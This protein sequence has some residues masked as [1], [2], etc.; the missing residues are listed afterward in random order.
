MPNLLYSLHDRDAHPLVP[1]GGWCIESIALNEN[2]QPQNWTQVRGDINWILRLNY[3]HNGKDGTIPL[4]GQYDEFA[5]RCTDYM[6]GTKGCNIVVIANEPNHEQE[7]PGGVPISPEDYADCFNLCFRAITNERPDVEVLTAAIAP[8]DITSGMDWLAYY[9]RMLAGVIECDGLAVHGYSHGADPDLIWSTEKKDGWYWHFPVI[10]QTIQAIPPEF[11]TRPI[12][13]TETDQGDNAWV[14]ANTGWV[15]NAYQSVNDHN[16]TPGTQ[17]ICSLALYRWRGDKYQIYNKNGVQDDFRAAV[18]HGYRSPLADIGPLPTPPTPEPP[19]PTPEPPRPT[20]EPEPDLDPRSID[21][22]LYARGVTFA[23]VKAPAGSGYW[24]IKA[25]RWLDE[26]EADAVG[27]DHHIL[28]SI[29]IDGSEVPDVP[30]KVTWPSGSANVVSKRDQPTATYNY[31]FPMS[32]SLN[33]FAIM[34]DDGPPSDL[35]MGIGMGKLGNPSIHTSTLIDWEWTISEGVIEPSPPT[36]PPPVLPQ[37]ERLI[38][39]VVGPVT[40]RWGENPD[41]YQQALGIPYHNG[42]DIGVPI[43]TEVRASGDGIIKWVDD[44]PQGY[45][46]YC[47]LYVPAV[48]QH[49]VTAHLDRCLVQ[50]GTEVKQGQVI[51]YSGNSGLSSGPHVH[52]ETRAGTEHS[53]AQG[54]FGNSNGRAD[55]QAVFWALGGTQEPIAGPGR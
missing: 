21:P 54:T 34:V 55:P 37:A 35:A 46:L 30:L 49:I 22:R 15:Q 31:D 47:R 9:K 14:D 51:A 26:V 27:P 10:Y 2:P 11:A 20:P 52:I 33:E 4:R 50:V 53:Y 24:R 48:R 3:A 42:V 12:H 40:Q 6:A 25:A 23:F 39:P 38:W 16:E 29:L 41:F 28:G 5:K 45:G 18:A 19:R 44:D 36:L 13:V 7:R 32:S 17:K 1:A 8:W 43:G